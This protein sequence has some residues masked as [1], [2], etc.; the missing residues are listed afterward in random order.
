M[1]GFID[2]MAAAM[3]DALLTRLWRSGV[4]LDAIAAEVALSP[5]E[6]CLAAV[7]LGLPERLQRPGMHEVSRPP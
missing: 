2:Q 6:V 5:S 1:S 3:R 7:R 4:G